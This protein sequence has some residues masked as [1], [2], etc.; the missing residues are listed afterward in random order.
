MQCSNPNSVNDHV[1]STTLKARFG[2]FV[3]NPV[4]KYA[5]VKMGSSSPSFG[6]KIP[7]IFELPPPSQPNETIGRCE[8]DKYN[9][10]KT[11]QNEEMGNGGGRFTLRYSCFLWISY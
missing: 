11:R 1:D 9:N 3:S 7:K 5:Q 8:S 6:V 10:K 4:E 2:R